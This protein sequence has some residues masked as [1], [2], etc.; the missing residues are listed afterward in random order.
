MRSI[1][2]K[3]N[4]TIGLL[5]K[6]QSVL[7]RITL[8]TI[9]K[10][11]VRPYLDYG[12]ILYDKAFVNSFHD[13]LEAIQYNTCL[14]ITGAIRGSPR[15]KLYQE[16]GLESLRLWR[17]YRKLCLFNKVFKNEHPQYFFHLIPVRHSPHTLNIPI[18]NVKHFV[19]SESLSFLLLSLNGI[20]WI[21]AF[22]V[23][24]TY[25]YRKLIYVLHFIRPAPI[26]NY[27]CHNP[28]GIKRN[29]RLR[30]GMSHL[31]GLKFKHNFLDSINPLRNCGH[32]IESATHCP[33]HYTLFI[34]KRSTFFSILRIL[35][36]RHW[37]QTLN[38][39]NILF[40]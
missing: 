8:V 20:T 15:E 6:L 22:L 19:F 33:L 24:E 18:L 31:R 7:P 13:R 32:D 1:L 35:D 30:F 12:D 5:C 11:F 40:K 37:T 36:C 21:Q 14:A 23:L 2:K 25:L 27:N 29:T 3:V 38:S 39:A 17:W 4:G 34:N 9:Y 26:S 10:A 28:K 16:L